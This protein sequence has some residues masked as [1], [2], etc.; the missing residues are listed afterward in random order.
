MAKQQKVAKLLAPTIPLVLEVEGDV[1]KLE[2]S[3][4]WTMGG[5]ILLESRLRRLGDEVNVLQEPASFWTE[6]DCTRLVTAVWAMSQQ[7]TQDYADEAGFDVIA[8][9]IITENLAAAS[10]ALKKAFIESLSKKRRDEIEVAEKEAL[11]LLKKG[12]PAESVP[13]PPTQAQV[14]S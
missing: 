4:S 5:V 9:Y 11:E 12:A 7:A 6:M 3:L 8:S 10:M 13:V 2:L 14:Q 1:P